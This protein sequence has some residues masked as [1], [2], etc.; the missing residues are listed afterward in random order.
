M[1]QSF[2]GEVILEAS[3]EYGHMLEENK[4]AFSI[5]VEQYSEQY[6]SVPIAIK[7]LPE[8]VSFLSIPEKVELFYK[9]PLT[10]ETPFTSSSFEVYADFSL[11]RR[12]FKELPLVLKKK[13]SNVT[14][15]WIKPQSI[16]YL[17][18]EQ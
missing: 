6:I 1:H 16:I 7:D 5:E 17:Y 18:N 11:V 4:I 15:V 10:Y 9:V 13:P 3:K 12:G 8:G 2:S 14:D